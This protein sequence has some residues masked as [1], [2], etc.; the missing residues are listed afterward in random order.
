MSMPGTVTVAVSHTGRTHAT[1]RAARAPRAAGGSVITITG[2]EGPLSSLADVD[3]RVTTF[4]HTDLT[5][6]VSRLAGLV[7]IDILATAVA[8]R[9]PQ[10]R[11]ER[12]TGMK[13]A[14][15]RMRSEG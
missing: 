11:R 15:A 10:E 14:L 9:A 2:D 7:V 1:I 5:P 4:E 3:I 6:M 12:V 13:D 8:L